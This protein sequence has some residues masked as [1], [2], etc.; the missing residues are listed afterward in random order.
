[1]WFFSNL[2]IPRNFN[3]IQAVHAVP[4]GKNGLHFCYYDILFGVFSEP[5]I[6]CKAYIYPRKKE[7]EEL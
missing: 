4:A 5:S 3:I 6:E 1:L 7:V 2:K